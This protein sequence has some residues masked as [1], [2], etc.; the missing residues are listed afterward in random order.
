M[1]S[2]EISLAK[3]KHL[4]N[5]ILV[6]TASE[7]MVPSEFIMTKV[8]YDERIACAFR[9]ETVERNSRPVFGHKEGSTISQQYLRCVLSCISI[10]NKSSMSLLSG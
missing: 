4:P 1:F 6:F 7:A 8:E 5:V 2:F 10:Q 9:I 3:F